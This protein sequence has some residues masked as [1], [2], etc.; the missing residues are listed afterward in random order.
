MEQRPTPK[1]KFQSPKE[2][3]DYLRNRISDIEKQYLKDS[4]EIPPKEKIVENVIEEYAKKESKEILA[5]KMQEKARDQDQI[6]LDL[7]PE[8]H[9][10]K[11]SELFHL[12]QTKG[13]HTTIGIV[14][15]LESPHIV[16]DFHR[17]LV[18]FIKNGYP[19][20]GLK[21]DSPDYKSIHRVLFE[22]SIPDNP[23][24][25]QEQSLSELISTMQQVYAGILS[26]SD[27]GSKDEY[28]TLEIAKPIENEEFV[29]YISVPET[30]VEMFKKQVHGF[31]PDV[32]IVMQPNDF[33]VFNDSGESLGGYLVQENISVRM[34][35]T[36]DKFETDPIKSILNVLS[37]LDN[38][39]EGA[40]VQLIFKP[41]GKFYE[42]HYL[43]GLKKLQEGKNDPKE[44][45][46]KN[47]ALSKFYKGVFDASKKA[48]K[49]VKVINT[50]S[51]DSG[52]KEPK[53]VD[54]TLV[55]N[56]QNKIANPI[57]S[58]NIR[59]VAS[60][61][62]RS[63][64]ES[65]VHDVVSAFNQFKLPAGNSLKLKLVSEK[66]SNFFQEF[67]YRRY[68]NHYDVPLN[69]AE[70]AIMF[71]FPKK[72][73]QKN[74]YL[75]TSKFV[76]AP[77]PID[78]KR[79]G[80][81]LGTNI[82]A[83]K[84][85]EIFMTPEDRLRH[86]YIIGQTGT[87]KTSLMKYM[88]YQDINNGDGV[89][90]IDPHGGDVSEV[91][92]NVPE[93]R[94]K[95]VIYFDPAYIQRPM[96]LN[97]LEYNPNFPEQKTFVVNE[98]FS[99]FQKLYG[100]G[101]PEALGP[102]FEQYF[103]N[104]AMLVVEDPETGNTLLDVSR[105]M[106]DSNF[107]KLKLSRCKNPV[108][109]EFW[110]NIAEKAGGEASLENVV[111][112]ITSKFDVFL[113]NEIMR[114]VIA[115][116]HSSFDF[117][118]IMDEKKILLVNLSKGRLGDIN[119]S[120]IGLILVGK[121][122]MAALSRVDQ[123]QEDLNPFYLYIDEFHNVTTDSI[124]TIL[125]EARKYKLGLIIAHQFIAQLEEGIKNS[126]FGNVGSL[127]TFRVGSDDADYLEK[128]YVPQFT[129]GDIMNIDNLNCYMKMLSGGIPKAPFSM[130]IIFAPRGDKQKLEE[131]KQ[132][133]YQTHG[134]DRA[135]VEAEIMKRYQKKEEGL[136]RRE[137]L[138]MMD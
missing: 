8:K 68:N 128:Q 116:E 136:V 32:N 50:K 134:R 130:H 23:R 34:L 101:N 43:K 40:S 57:V 5:P 12:V 106:A 137:S 35:K 21:K 94:K 18:S 64:T 3:L 138:D 104:A 48:E 87:G 96:G 20:Y 123:R 54:Q 78:L 2:E 83:G 117:R 127:A 74:P 59:V 47:N 36:V 77:A 95:D 121:I 33:N 99:I 132:Y 51:K 129:A 125:S 28:M 131:M 122:L 9:D 52:P 46:I 45:S 7:E 92:A 73:E 93:H 91:L 42:K 82:H 15:K 112:Y 103:R 135:E 26:I 85:K 13:I 102:M 65:I 84:E 124:S 31:F 11:M 19:D 1:E 27:N 88:I 6:V 118:K 22:I 100:K 115:Q 133:L 70:V 109:V 56:V 37:N 58:T 29:F 113:A 67:T 61:K 69:L 110:K 49:V 97:M 126:V 107:R 72:T 98:L 111:P 17:F 38:R 90:M 119:S 63:K 71:H 105:V 76:T 16:D 79:E 86:M 120:L 108:V 4:I 55:E 14:S 81:L 44:L 30:K 114:P 89:C 10:N 41:V 80:V 75:K 60:S 39:E 53:P 25:Q 62:E 66:D 24:S